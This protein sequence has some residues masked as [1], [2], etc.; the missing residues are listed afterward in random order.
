MKDPTF[1]SASIRGYSMSFKITWSGV[2]AVVHDHFGHV[3]VVFALLKIGSFQPSTGDLFA[4]RET[5]L[6]VAASGWLSCSEDKRWINY[7][8]SVIFQFVSNDLS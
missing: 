7:C 5:L 6:L 2:G 1:V 3:R 8:P 4:I